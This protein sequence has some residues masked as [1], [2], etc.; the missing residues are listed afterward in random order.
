MESI[1]DRLQ[2]ARFAAGFET[3]Q[4]AV[5]RYGWTYST[6]SGHENGS[7]GVRGEALERYAR[8]FGVDPGWLQFG[9]GKG[10]AATPQPAATATAGHFAEPSA[11]PYIP[12]SDTRERALLDLARHLAPGV[13]HPALF[14]MNATCL[15]FGLIRGDL[16]V[17]DLKP[18]P[19]G[20][21]TALIT[22]A[23][24][25]TGSGHTA[26]GRIIG[27]A[28][29]WPVGSDDD[30]PNRTDDQSVAVM[31]TVAAVMRQELAAR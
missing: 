14:R 26:I 1:H 24:S 25:D 13:H 15:D 21:G 10:P 20:D 8:A 17:I 31:G 27:T 16:L 28:I 29:A 3:A 12:P 6:Y 9:R 5:T 11:E 18:A 7:R 22:V 23:D 4:D 19:G 2:R 30:M